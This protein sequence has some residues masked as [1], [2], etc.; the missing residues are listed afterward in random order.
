MKGKRMFRYNMMTGEPDNGSPN[1]N[2]G[3]MS[4]QEI[5][6]NA[7]LIP[8]PNQPGGQ[9]V[10]N[11]DARF[12]P[13]YTQTMYTQMSGPYPGYQNPAMM[14][15][16]QA[17]GQFGYNMPMQ[18]QQQPMQQ[19]KPW[20][21]DNMMKANGGGIGFMNPPQYPNGYGNGYSSY[22]QPQYQDQTYVIPAFNFGSDT[23]FPADIEDRIA[24]LQLSLY[25]ELEESYVERMK[26]QSAYQNNMGWN[27]YYGPNMMIDDPAII[28]KYQNIAQ[29]IRNEAIERRTNFNKNLVRAAFN[30]AYGPEN[31]D[32]EMIERMFTPVTV[33]I[34]AEQVQNNAHQD[35][36][37]RL[38]PCD[39]NAWYYR[40]MT[41]K[42]SEE[43]NKYFPKGDRTTLAEYL[44]GATE[45]LFDMSLEEE[46]HKRRN[47]QILYRQ[48]GSYRELLRAK[49]MERKGLT[50]NG[51]IKGSDEM[52]DLTNL[53]DSNG[54]PGTAFPTL[55]ASSTRLEDG[56]IL[57]T[58]P[59]WITE[60]EGT[61]E[62]LKLKNQMESDYERNR[63]KFID[64][65]F[66][67][68]PRP[69][70]VI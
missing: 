42:A 35:F 18:I 63:G 69:G 40:Q 56:S 21:Y 57:I 4:T 7:S 59:P 13:M 32:D 49:I 68:D 65:I 50:N 24:E 26:R 67:R 29:E 36:L 15:M 8:P 66:N 23:L 48:D 9:Y 17:N 33:T 39:G 25:N 5:V 53:I 44:D 38:V 1:E 11:T 41:I 55:R 27:G 2:F 37:N 22:N 14:Q 52:P 28:N 6:N 30:V 43:H 20:Y 47:G 54:M 51:I 34:P 61:T 10:Y 60:K 31:V 70:G 58:P 45:M 46:K 19:N 3:V 16:M 64:S 12:G 62:S